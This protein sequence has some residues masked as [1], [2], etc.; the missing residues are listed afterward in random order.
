MRT[1]REKWLAFGCCLTGLNFHIVRSCSELS[2]KRV[3]KYTSSLLVI[4]LLWAFIGY[5]FTDRYLKGT[6]FACIMGIVLMVFVVIQIERQIIL[7]SKDNKM[8]HGFRVVLGIAMALIGT[9]IIDQI[10]FKEDIAKRKLITMDE[11][12]KKIFPGRAEELKNQ[13]AEIVSTIEAKE[14][15]RKAITDDISAN[16]FVK[17][18]E[19]VVQRDTAKNES[20]TITRKNL[21]NPKFQLVEPLDKAILGLREEKSKKDSTLLG[22]R[23]VIEAELKQNVGFLDELEVMYALLS[24]SGVSLCAW[25]IWFV[26]LLGLE[27]LILASKIGETETDYDRMMA[28]QMNIHFTKIELLGRR[29]EIN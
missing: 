14:F 29:A 4:S 19:R 15:E 11:E 3:I 18:F 17:V 21:P 8:L 5:A 13:I 25:L 26:F 27:L 9:V 28:Q 10:I 20:V 12:V 23:P 6:W 1:F 24:E 7:S 16:P 2:M 22:L